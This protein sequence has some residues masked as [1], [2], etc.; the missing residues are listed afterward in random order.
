[1]RNY[2]P[3]KLEL[4]TNVAH[5]ARVQER[6]RRELAGYYAQIENLDWNYG[7]VVQ[8]LQDTG[9]LENTHIFFFADHGE[10]MG[11]HGMFRKVNPYEEAIKT[12]MLM[13][14]GLPTYGGWKRGRI[15]VVSNSVDIAPT[16]LGLCGIAKT[17]W[18]EGTD[19]SHYR[20]STSK[21]GPEPDSAYLQN[22]IPVGH[23]ESINTAYRGLVTKDGWKYVCFENMSWLMFNVNE[24]P[25]EEANLA[26]NNAY[27][28]ER[29]KLI[30][31]LKQW[32]AD[33]GD[34]FAIPES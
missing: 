4:R 34:K 25:F 16:T 6:T 1:M 22:V 23:P 12:P 18:M 17:D 3:E 28:A 11:S 27:R 30:A 26:Q 20:V 29:K 21:A 33:T 2:Q 24:D 32:V 13:S 15:P 5:V 14:G 19:Y 8:A 7:R 10:M 9:Q 31:R